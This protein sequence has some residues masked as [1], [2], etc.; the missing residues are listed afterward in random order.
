MTV[1]SSA[2]TPVPVDELRHSP[3]EARRCELAAS[4][5]DGRRGVRLR[6]EP[7][8]TQVDVRAEAPS[9]SR[10]ER[11]LGR[12]PPREPNA[13][14]GDEHEA[15]LWLGPDEWL[16]V[17][18]DGRAARTVRAVEEALAG[19]PG[20][21]VDVSANRTTVR[22]EGPAAR[23]VLEKVCS[24]DLHPRVFGTGRCAQTLV[25]RSQAVLWQVG[26]TPGYR[27]FVRNSFANYLA[28]L[29]LDAVAEFGDA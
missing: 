13:V 17:G 10:V 21:V 6:E 2:R 3:L 18:P 12:T 23:E 26:T 16:V 14:E 7:F 24:V 15:V 19:T 1:L 11:A 5:A 20:S 9:L 8:L 4:G 25:G 22:L 27:L 28:D 29:L